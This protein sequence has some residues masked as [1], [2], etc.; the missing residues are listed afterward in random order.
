MTIGF[1]DDDGSFRPVAI[2]QL[3]EDKILYT[4]AL[5]R[6]EYKVDCKVTE[7]KTNITK[8]EKEPV[9]DCSKGFLK[10]LINQLPKG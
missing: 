3:S 8:D 2:K 5:K 6:C 1:K 9:F 4:P 10:L 7:V